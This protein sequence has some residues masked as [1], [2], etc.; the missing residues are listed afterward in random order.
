MLCSIF[1]QL[2]FIFVLQAATSCRK[3]IGSFLLLY[4]EFIHGSWNSTNFFWKVYPLILSFLYCVSDTIQACFKRIDPDFVYQGWK[5]IPLPLEFQSGWTKD[6]RQWFE[7]DP[8]ALRLQDHWFI[9]LSACLLEQQNFARSILLQV[10]IK[11]KADCPRIMFKCES[12][13]QHL[14]PFY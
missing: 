13:P 9:Y 1:L 11:F 3:K 7:Q 12:S 2:L 10:S 8:V 5:G 14:P 4:V 6:G